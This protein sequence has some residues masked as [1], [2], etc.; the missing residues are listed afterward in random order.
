[1]TFLPSS[2]TFKLSYTPKFT[3][4]FLDT[5]HANVL[6][7][8]K[9]NTNSPDP[10][11]GKC[12]QCA[13]L[14]RART[15]GG[16]NIA[17]SDFC[18]TCFKQYCFDPGNPPSRDALPGRKLDHVDPD[19]QGTSKVKEFFSK[20]KGPVI[21]GFVSLV[22]LVAGLVGGLCVFVSRFMQN[23]SVILMGGQ[24]LVEEAQGAARVQ[25][26]ERAPYRRG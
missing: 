20:E 9:P 2:G 5:T 11:F 24:A 23:E 22:A 21:G 12:L 7:G 15:K 10:D 16:K 3:Q 25:A 8:F 14:D 26:R 13:A 4:L 17:R 18:E 19:P 6:G 1:L